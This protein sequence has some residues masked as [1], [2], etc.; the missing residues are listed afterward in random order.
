MNEIKHKRLFIGQ[1][2]NVSF[3]I[4]KYYDRCTS[5]PVFAAPKSDLSGV[6][7]VAFI[8]MTLVATK[9]EAKVELLFNKPAC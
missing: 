9:A 2:S 3:I 7:F 6:K 5:K 1:K 8:V 4:I